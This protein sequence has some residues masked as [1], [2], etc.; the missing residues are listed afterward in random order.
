MP[1]F[2]EGIVIAAAGARVASGNEERVK[3]DGEGNALHRVAVVRV[4]YLRANAEVPD[5][6]LEERTGVLLGF[7]DLDRP[8]DDGPVPYVDDRV[9]VEEY[10]GDIGLE[11][12]DVP[13]PDLVRAGDRDPLGL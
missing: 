11:P 6:P 5:D 13:C 1:G 7:G 12:G 10:P 8:S 2:D 4:D 9:G 3:K